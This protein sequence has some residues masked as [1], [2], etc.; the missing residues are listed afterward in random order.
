MIPDDELCGCGV[1][2][3]ADCECPPE[4]AALC[5]A[6]REL[7][8]TRDAAEADKLRR[9][10][11]RLWRPYCPRVPEA[12]ARA[13]STWTQPG[14]RI[15]PWR[16]MYEAD[17]RPYTAPELRG[18]TVDAGLDR[19][20]R[21]LAE[22]VAVLGAMADDPARNALRTPWAVLNRAGLLIEAARRELPADAPA[23]PIPF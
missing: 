15:E 20:M 9:S 12:L 19:V 22:A 8:A 5:A 2:P 7:T 23:E 1:Q 11:A 21:A 16:V 13:G 3:A 17:G 4:D 14:T 10:I 18:R 6:M